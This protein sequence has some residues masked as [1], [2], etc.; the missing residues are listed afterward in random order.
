MIWLAGNGVNWFGGNMKIG[1]LA[2]KWCA[3]RWLVGLAVLALWTPARFASAQVATNANSVPQAATNVVVPVPVQPGL[4]ISGTQLA[5]LWAIL[6]KEGVNT[7][8]DK[9]S[10]DL[11]G[12]TTKEG[13]SLTVRQLGTPDTADVIRTI[14]ILPDEKGYLFV[15]QNPKTQ[16]A[17]F[18]WCN[19]NF[20][21]VAGIPSIEGP[22]ALKQDLSFWALV[23]DKL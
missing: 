8:I 2:I 7:T 16:K 5:K 15:D 11:L 19:K 10:T 14:A 9:P 21:L 4:P 13:K 23:A 3:R 6:P 1:K 20:S 17:R 22:D 18:V 12:L